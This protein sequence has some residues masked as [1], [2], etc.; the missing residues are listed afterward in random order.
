MLDT[1]E[2]SRETLEKL[3]EY[4]KGE[5][6]DRN[7]D[8][9]RFHLIDQL[10]VGCLGW[11]RPDI[12]TEPSH[13]GEYADYILSITRT[14]A[15][16]EAKREGNYFELHAG[17]KGNIL[18]LK[19]LRKDNKELDKAIQQVSGYCHRR[20]V[21]VA[22]VCNGW[23]IVAFVANRSDSIA[24]LEGNALV[25]DSLDGMLDNF[26]DFWNYLSKPGMEKKTLLHKLLGNAIVELPHKLSSRIHGYPGIKNRNTYQN[27]AQIISD[28][29]L[30]DAVREKDI[31]KQF[32]EECYCNSG[33]LSGYTLVS[34]E[35]LNTRYNYLFQDND[36]KAILEPVSS[37]KG[38]NKNL[39]D[40]VAN[41]ISKRPILLVGDVGAGKST[42]VNN[43][44]QV[45]APHEFEK[46]LVLKV[47]LGSQ[48]IVALDM[49]ATILD[50]LVFQMKNIHNID[51][52]DDDFVRHC[53][54]VDLNE[55]KKSVIVKRLYEIDETQAFIKEIEFLSKKVNDIAQHL[56]KSLQHI[57]KSQK[58][59]IVI[60]I[61]NCD[62]RNDSDQET[63][64]LI[65]QEFASEWAVIVFLSLR[66]ET[67]HR[68]KKS[69]G[70]LSGY[71]TKAFT[72]APPKIE[73]VITKR[74]LF[75]Q[76][77]ARGETPVST[78]N[79]DVTFSKLDTL[80]EVLLD[81][82]DYNKG[83]YELIDNI[84]NG[85]IRKSIEMI[86]DFF[87]SGH[88]DTEKMVSVNKYIVSVH[89]FLRAVIYGDN[90]YYNPNSSL[91]VNMFDVRYHDP[92]EH[93]IIPVLLGVLRSFSLSSR[94]DG[95]VDV[96]TVYSIVQG[97]A[98]NPDQ[99]DSA[100]DTAYSKGM[101]ETSEKGSRLSHD[102][103]IKLRITTLGA[104]HILRL[105]SMFVYIDAVVVD[106]PLFGRDTG[107]N[108]TAF[109]M[110]DR[111]D[112]AKKFK[113]Y[114]DSQWEQVSSNG[115]Y[116]DWKAESEALG[117]QIDLVARRTGIS[118]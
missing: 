66:P 59:Q 46:S 95:F 54:F 56:K 39:V 83:L 91:I 92:K 37:K 93:F 19:T 98:F 77:I 113:E 45:E 63:A 74:L 115:N 99:V 58:K 110:A 48:A 10:L 24:P 33:A 86:K 107:W 53:Y 31:E 111:I 81:S 96:A 90:I 109:N 41:S 5:S 28:I 89:E 35:I 102:A 76:K 55:F 112:R 32:L 29:V 97:F 61:D 72:I 42:F 1:Y 30:E 44:L 101:L 6:L 65:S 116:F 27:E 100:I 94:N 78:L 9:T 106:T 60:F 12:L 104:Y 117:Q 51:I 7:E 34:K 105:P 73:D 52:M 2:N 26:L 118:S 4:F 108:R 84:S 18:S 36:K 70:A 40:V 49:K 25:F 43:L 13:E 68:A 85:N 88:I 57:S 79:F 38:L 11:E 8:T 21:Q 50:E 16:V 20:G 103:P 71:H 87:G 67:F 62:Q 22:I 75:A 82:L 17:V 23:Q 47:D 64:F 3:A 69:T 114:L 80:I 15:I 14:V